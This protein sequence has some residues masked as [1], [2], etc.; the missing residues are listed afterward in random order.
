MSRNMRAV[1]VEWGPSA[2]VFVSADQFEELVAALMGEEF[3][4]TCEWNGADEVFKFWTK[5][6]KRFLDRVRGCK[7]DEAL[8][9]IDESFREEA[10][11]CLEN[12]KSL[13]PDWRQFLDKDGQIEVW[14]DGY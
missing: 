1:R 7:P 6:G 10:R 14:V 12:L 13:E 5:E 8:K 3:K 4:Y 9:Q 2:S 11:L